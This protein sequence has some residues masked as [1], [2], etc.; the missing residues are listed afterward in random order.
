[1]IDVIK[2]KRLRTEARAHLA[3]YAADPDMVDLLVEGLLDVVHGMRPR[4]EEAASVLLEAKA[5]E[6]LA[7]FGAT[8]AQMTAAPTPR[9]RGG[10]RFTHSDSRKANRLVARCVAT[11]GTLVTACML[12]LFGV[13]CSGTPAPANA[14]RFAPPTCMDTHDDGSTVAHTLHLG[15]R[16]DAPTHY[17]LEVEADGVTYLLPAR[18][19]DGDESLKARV[20]TGAPRAW[21]NVRVRVAVLSGETWVVTDDVGHLTACAVE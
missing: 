18:E 1:M 17:R 12:A 20:D 10:M 16:S 21:D 11:A 13:G 15:L 14:V 19:I 9:T 8:L 4:D 2:S 7:T 5:R 3:L 6:Y